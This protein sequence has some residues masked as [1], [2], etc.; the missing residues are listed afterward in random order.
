ML[1][2]SVP[3]TDSTLDSFIEINILLL[4]GDIKKYLQHQLRDITPRVKYVK[5][6]THTYI[7]KILG[8]DNK[9]LT[10]VLRTTSNS[11]LFAKWK[12]TS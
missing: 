9:I 5:E 4:H 1:S 6:I 12:S 11:G 7:W 3:L 8:I 10:A 2:C